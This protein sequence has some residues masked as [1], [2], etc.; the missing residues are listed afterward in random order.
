MGQLNTEISSQNKHKLQEALEKEVDELM[1]EIIDYIFSE[2]R[3]NIVRNDTIGVTNN[4]FRKVTLDKTRKLEKTLTFEAPYA[5]FIEYGTDPHYVNYKHLIEWAKKKAGLNDQD[6]KR[7]AYFV[8]KKIK[9]NGMKA[10]PFLRPAMAKAKK[11]YGS[12]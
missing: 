12:L 11:K 7:M 10:K 5:D 2:A 8:S 6:A 4:L 9:E 1:N 3:E